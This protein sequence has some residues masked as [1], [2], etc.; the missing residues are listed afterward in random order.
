[1]GDVATGLLKDSVGA[2]KLNNDPCCARLDT[3]SNLL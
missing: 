1:M 2:Q 3:A